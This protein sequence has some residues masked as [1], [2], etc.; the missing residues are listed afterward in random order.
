MPKLHY[1]HECTGLSEPVL[2]ALY[3]ASFFLYVEGTK[4]C[5]TVKKGKNYSRLCKM[6]PSLQRPGVLCWLNVLPSR[7]IR[8]KSGLSLAASPSPPVKPSVKAERDCIVVRLKWAS[9]YTCV[10]RVH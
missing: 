4:N 9:Y 7:P 5:D 8:S 3:F 10:K 2:T 1:S 6:L